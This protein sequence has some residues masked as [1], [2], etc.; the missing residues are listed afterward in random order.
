MKLNRWIHAAWVL[1]AWIVLQ[2]MFGKL[3]GEQGLLLA[4]PAHIGGFIAGMI[5]QKPLLLW[6]YRKA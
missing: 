6:R 2:W 5:L 1:A 4:T 3:A